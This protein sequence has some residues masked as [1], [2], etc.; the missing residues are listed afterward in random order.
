V[1]RRLVAPACAGYIVLSYFVLLN[2]LI[3]VF[4]STFEK[5]RAALRE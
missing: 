5:V 3:A 1:S 4:N 2:L